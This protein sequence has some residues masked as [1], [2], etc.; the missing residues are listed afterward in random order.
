MKPPNGSGVEY[1]SIVVDGET[2]TAKVDLLVLY[3][4][5]SRKIDLRTVQSKLSNPDDPEGLM[6]AMEI[7]AAITAHNFVAKRQPA[8][9]GQQWALKLGD[10]QRLAEVNDLI[11]KAVL[12]APRADGT[13][14]APEAPIQGQRPS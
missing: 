3:E 5:S 14:V 2:F 12:K 8:L 11:V 10:P 1:P 9:T 6:L 4:L 7:F 13:P